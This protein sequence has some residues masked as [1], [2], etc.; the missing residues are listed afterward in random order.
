MS[1]SQDSQF[2]NGGNPLYGSEF[3]GD[4]IILIKDG[5][6]ISDFLVIS[7][8]QFFLKLKK[9]CVRIPTIVGRWVLG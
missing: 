8:P 7:M 4:S 3:E 2:A 1:T 5:K 9:D 6:S